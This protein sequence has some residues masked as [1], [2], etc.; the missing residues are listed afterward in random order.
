MDSTPLWIDVV[1][2]IADIVTMVA[3]V[4]GGFIGYMRY[5]R[6][7]IS[8]SKLDLDV[9]LERCQLGG[10]DALKVVA[11]IKNDGTC[12]VGFPPI[13]TQQIQVS[14]CY[15]QA[16]AP[17]WSNGRLWFAHWATGEIVATNLAGTSEVVGTGPTGLGWLSEGRV[18]VTGDRLMRHEPDGRTGAR[19]AARP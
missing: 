18:L 4:L 14:A 12:R 9:L 1:G 3:I 2:A 7:R 10:R 11:S 5:L 16:W 17:R 19:G 6:G 15:R 8:H 13:T